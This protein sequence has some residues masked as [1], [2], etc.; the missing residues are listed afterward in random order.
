ME[1]QHKFKVSSEASG[2]RVDKFLATQNDNLSRNYLQNLIKDGQVLVNDKQVKKSYQL[3]TD[4]QIELTIPEA[5]EMDLEPE[6]IH[7]DI[8]YEDQDLI[9][10]NKQPDL[11]VHP[12]PGHP[13]GTLVNALLYHCDN[14]S[15]IN[16]V[17]RP[18]IVHRLDKDTSGS[19]VVAK[20]D[21]THR[22]L[23]NQFKER[24]TKKEY[25]AL[26]QG[27][28]KYNKGKID[29]AI[30]RDPSDRKKMAVT[31]KN[32]KRAISHFEVQKRYQDHTL[33]KVR[34]ETGRTHQ[35][36][37]HMD[38][39]SNAVVGDQLYGPTNSKLDV[40]RQMLHAHKLGFYHPRTEVWK[41]FKAPLLADMKETIANLA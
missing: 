20:N 7:L 27:Q 12:A 34:L 41:E 11:V 2:Q 36:R 3:E 1:E 21:E 32:S 23:A 24:E 40:S 28:V 13:N 4:D 6:D 25:L 19:L 33:V 15:G 22:G 26:V 35:I 39:M 17:I 16:G 10:I 8:L 5:E 37:L 30:G 14:L 18:G 9:V 31:S 38:Y 29:A